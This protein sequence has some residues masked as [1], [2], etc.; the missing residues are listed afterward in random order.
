MDVIS[1]PLSAS[2]LISALHQVSEIEGMGLA[3]KLLMQN[4]TNWMGGP[5]R[6]LFKLDILKTGRFNFLGGEN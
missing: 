1:A 6:F 4:K 3:A 5:Q 2:F